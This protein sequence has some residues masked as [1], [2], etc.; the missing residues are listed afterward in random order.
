MRNNLNTTAENSYK[1]LDIIKINKYNVKEVGKVKIVVPQDDITV[2]YTKVDVVLGD[3]KDFKAGAAD[4]VMDTEFE[5]P[6]KPENKE[7]QK[8]EV[9]EKAAQKQEEIEI[10]DEDVEMKESPD[11]ENKPIDMHVEE[12]EFSPPAEPPEETDETLD[13]YTPV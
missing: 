11:K 9:G 2:V 13:I 12:K 7:E 10:S 1:K 6:Y 3:P 8:S 5:I 4:E